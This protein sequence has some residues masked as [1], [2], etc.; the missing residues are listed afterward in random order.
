VLDPVILGANSSMKSLP[1]HL[2]K[3]SDLADAHLGVHVRLYA[4]GEGP[5]SAGRNFPVPLSN[6][7]CISVISIVIPNYAFLKV[8]TSL[9]KTKYI[10]KQWKFLDYILLPL[11][12]LF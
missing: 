2:D 7:V 1:L 11:F 4:N 3:F 5:H 12:Y 6:K 9:V 8:F 10:L